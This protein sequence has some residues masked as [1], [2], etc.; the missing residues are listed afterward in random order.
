MSELKTHRFM[1]TDE[2]W[3]NAN[4]GSDYY[5][6]PEADKVIADLKDK[7][8]MHDFFWEGCGFAKRG[9]KNSIAVSEAFEK[10]LGCLKYLVVRDLI[11]DC[12][13]KKTAAELVK[14]YDHENPL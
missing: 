14:E 11:K 4:V 9:F 7:C 10:L 2:V 8:Q 3:A 13:P 12:P 5:S 6:K 1:S